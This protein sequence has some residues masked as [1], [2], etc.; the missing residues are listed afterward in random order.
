MT[1]LSSITLPKGFRA[2]GGTAGLKPSGKPDLALI[3]AD[4][5]C[6]WAA[7]FTQNK[8]CGAPVTVGREH[9]KTS[10]FRGRAF[11]VN[12][13]CSNVA[14]GARGIANAKRMCDALARAIGCDRDQVLP[15][16]TGVIGRHLPIDKITAG[17]NALVP[18]LARGPHA[19]ADAAVAILTTDLVAKVAHR[20]VKIGGKTVTLAG[21][22]KGSGMIAPNM[23]TMLVFLTTDADIAPPLLRRA[24]IAAVN[25]DASFNR[26]SVDTDTSTSDTVAILASGYAGNTPIRQAN[27]HFRGFQK[28]LTDLCTDLAYQVIKD[29]EGAEHVIRVIV[30]GAHSDADA[31]KA[32]R[33]IADSPLVKTAVHGGD[34]NWGRIAAAA[35]RSGGGAR[36]DPQKFTI[37]VGKITVYR[38]AQ[39]A[40]FDV[41]SAAAE[42][43]LPEVVIR[44]NLNLGKSSATFLGCDLSRQ[45]IAINADYTT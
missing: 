30:T 41:K 39:P 37:K 17:I 14:T 28:A 24:L 4:Q 19:D 33:T 32:A 44:V 36:I 23:A 7:V 25:A 21:I 3:V 16:S 1:T 9:L 12:S 8:V 31:V 29:G 35:G 15:A 45:Y 11:V 42:M 22:A 10:N 20:T 5:P 2:A 18:R 38:N 40:K 43:K 34:P 13:G 26:I 27:E 6:P